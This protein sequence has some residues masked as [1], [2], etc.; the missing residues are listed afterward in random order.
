M[1]DIYSHINPLMRGMEIIYYSLKKNGFLAPKKLDFEIA[2]K[3]VRNFF[4]LSVNETS[5]FTFIFMNYYDYGE[6]PVSIAMLAHEAEILPMRFLA[7][8][9]EFNSLERKGFIYEDS[10]DDPLSDAIYYRVPEEVCDAIIKNDMYLLE[11]GL[12]R[13][14]RD[15]T[16]P[17]SIIEKELF[18]PDSIRSDIDSLADYLMPNKFSEIQTRF[19]DKKM[20]TGVC[21]M[22]YGASGTGKTE[23]VFQIAKKTD[24]AILHIDI[25]DIQSMWHGATVHNLSKLFDHY[26]E[27]CN[28]AK[29]KGENIPILLFNEADALFGRRMKPPVQ[30]A[31]IDENHIQSVLLDYMEKQEGIVIATTNLAENLDPAFERR[32]IFKIKFESPDNTIKQKIWQNKATW[33][34]KPVALHLAERYA[35]SGAEIENVVRKATMKEVLTGK[36]SSLQELEDYCQKEKLSENRIKHIGF[37]SLL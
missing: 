22:L 37:E 31:E 14:E 7:F 12:K 11:N 27:L 18:Y 23:T 17:E 33:L 15:L 29:K 19:F 9:E 35:L 4:S 20:P 28:Q 36:R 34:K 6:R 30:G 13:N 21:I 8:K 3:R 25:G 32:F 1:S 16:Y 24:R 26:G 10:I 2:L 5:L